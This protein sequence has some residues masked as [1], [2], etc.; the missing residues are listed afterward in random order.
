MI[1]RMQRLLKLKARALERRILDRGCVKRPPA[2]ERRALLA[3]VRQAFKPRRPP[4]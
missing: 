4:L 2:G 3:A 1:R